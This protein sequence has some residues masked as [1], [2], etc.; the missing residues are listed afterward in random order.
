MVGRLPQNG[1]DLLK[2]TPRK[3][4]W[5]LAFPQRKG[6][7]HHWT[8]NEVPA[9][10]SCSFGV[11]QAPIRNRSHKALASQIGCLLRLSFDLVMGFQKEG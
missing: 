10:L 8:L 11:A 7:G 2:E 4:C 3:A 6:E 1:C 9:P 5:L